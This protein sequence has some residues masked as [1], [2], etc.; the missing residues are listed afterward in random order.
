MAM[1]S[2]YSRFATLG[3]TTVPSGNRTTKN[4]CL[5]A[6]FTV[7]E[8]QISQNGTGCVLNSWCFECADLYVVKGRHEIGCYLSSL[9]FDD[10][11]RG[12]LLPS[13]E[14]VLKCSA[15]LRRAS[16]SEQL[17]RQGWERQHK[18]DHR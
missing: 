13:F 3:T 14:D 10:G 12:I 17:N 2:S 7:S 11:V 6:P 9:L 1:W 5:N 4:S 16:V 8:K 15:V 18:Q